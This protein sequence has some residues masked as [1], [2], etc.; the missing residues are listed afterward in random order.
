[1]C[2]NCYRTVYCPCNNLCNNCNV[3]E[4]VGPILI[5]ALYLFFAYLIFFIGMILLM[6]F[7]D[8]NPTSQKIDTRQLK[9]N[10]RKNKKQL[11]S[12]DISTNSNELKAYNPK[13]IWDWLNY[14]ADS[15]SN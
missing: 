3:F 7:I 1:M 2:P 4:W 10:S 12:D 9:K 11:S 6:P 13:A 15:E 14:D 8:E 5:I